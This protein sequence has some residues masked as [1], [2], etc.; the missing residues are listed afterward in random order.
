MRN[1]YNLH[2]LAAET[3]VL[4]VYVEY[5]LA[6]EHKIPVCYDDS[7]VSQHANG[8]LG[9]EPWLKSHADISEFSCQEFIM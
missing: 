6:P 7:W 4:V 8:E 9:T 5:R 2:S 3:S 1:F